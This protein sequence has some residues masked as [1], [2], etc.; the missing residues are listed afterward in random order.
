MDSSPY[1]ANGKENADKK[2]LFQLEV[3][4]KIIS[5]KASLKNGQKLKPKLFVKVSKF[6]N[7]KNITCIFI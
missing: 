6:Q 4:P 7:S 5:L 2:G 1:K 3:S